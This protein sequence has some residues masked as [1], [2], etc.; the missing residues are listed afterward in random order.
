MRPES[1]LGGRSRREFLQRAALASAAVPGLARASG[2]RPVLAYVGTYSSPQGPEGSK[3][4]GSGIHVFELNPATG[5]LT[6]HEVVASGLN[7]SHLAPDADW[8]HVYSANETATFEGEASGS[9]SAYKVDPGSG[10]LTLLNTVSS[11]GAGPC[12]VSVHPSGKHVFAAN[13]HGGTFAVLPVLAGG[14]LGP[15]SDVKRLSGPVGPTKSTSAPGGSFAISGHDRTHGHMIQ[16][17]P[18]GRFVI[19]ADLGADR[20][21]VWRYD[22]A[23]GSLADNDP[24][25]VSVPAGDGPRHFSFHPNGRWVYSLQEEGSTLIAFDY[26]A[27]KGVFAAKQTLSSLPPGFSGSNFTSEVMVSPDG[28]FVYAA[29]RM[30]DSIAWFS[31][32]A[33]GRLKFAGEV[34]TRG[35]Y[36]RSFNFDPTGG[37]LFSCN[38]RADAITTFR[39][40]KTTGELTFTGAYTPVGTPSCIVFR[41]A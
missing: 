39:V 34:W 41:P 35:D 26:D 30:H 13:Y 7:P 9:V 22:A 11:K 18:S 8:T 33:E 2:G 32:G 36:P 19:G 20:I 16:A 24:S 6:P 21:H 10:H 14:G 27:N 15:A 12:Y 38:Q 29:N 1:S 28:R 3:G 4:Y 31:I 17:D 40:N 37:F 23:H 5:A 25:G